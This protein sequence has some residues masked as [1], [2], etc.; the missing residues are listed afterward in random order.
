[1]NS[2]FLGHLESR[3]P[4]H[5]PRS[6]FDTH[7]H[8]IGRTGKGKTTALQTIFHNLLGD[9]SFE[10][11]VVIIDRLGGL[12]F[13][14]L[15]WLA[16]DY[17]P[18]YVRERLVYVEP[19]R[20][21][22]VLG[23]NPLLPRCEGE[24]YYRVFRAV[25][26][27]LRGWESQ[28]IEKMP[29][30]ARWLFNSFY[31]CSLS[32]LTIADSAHLLSPGTD[33]HTA[34]LR[35]L[36]T[37][38]KTEWE[39]LV[40]TSPNQVAITLDSTRNRLKPFHEAPPLRRMFGATT[41]G[42]DMLRFMKEGK[43]LLLNLSAGNRLPEHVSDAI[44][45]LII[46]EVMTTA[47]SLPMGVRYP[48][49]MVLDEFQR[50]VGPD[51][52]D[53]IPEVRQLG[54]KLLLSHQSMSQLKVGETDLTSMIFQAQSRM[55][56]GLQGED[57]D[58]LA[59]ELASLTF[60]P[61]KIKNELFSQKQRIVGHRSVQ[62]RS[63]STSE[64]DGQN[65]ME[66]YG[67]NSSRSENFQYREI[68]LPIRSAGKSDGDSQGGGSGGSSG[69]SVTESVNETLVPIHQDYVE[70]M[71]RTYTTFDE[72]WHVWGRNVRLL[73]KGMAFV[74][75]VDN[76]N[77]YT[78]AVKRSVPG[79]LALDVERITKDA[80]QLL[81]EVEELKEENF[82]QECFSSPASIDRETQER[83]KNILQKPISAGG[84]LNP[85]MSPTASESE[86]TSPFGV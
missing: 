63:Y 9:P 65:W 73:R 50:F 68:G 76:A 3:R 81:D 62:T 38:L 67:R 28:D 52:R 21:D 36:P 49:Y 32:G 23:F 43:I 56:F 29:R 82:K 37:E 33:L 2:Y 48:T 6:S 70:L 58:I 25:D 83:L 27:I 8:F 42:L 10:P 69:R 84:P 26:A 72:D 77:L 47:R 35:T 74:R 66:N 1:M 19:A 45:G 80:P 14:L 40:K 34:I 12:S 24:R 4:F 5:L 79:Y 41:G 57:A 18:S 51:I 7:W 85:R 54:I 13:D 11:C 22:V 53:A 31:A 64:S 46:N 39:S 71:N 75:L 55:I 59:H 61:Y 60:D 15:R 20:D 86:T 78:V 44:G 30:L 17:C 16:S